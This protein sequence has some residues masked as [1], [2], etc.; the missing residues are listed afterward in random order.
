VL[1]EQAQ[2]W[3]EGREKRTENWRKFNDKKTKLIQK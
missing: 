2:E 1:K 3:D